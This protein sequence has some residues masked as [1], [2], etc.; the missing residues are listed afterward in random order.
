M[1]DRIPLDHLTSDALDA[2]YE[3]LEA[4][5]QTESERQLAT[6]REALASATTRAARAEVTVARVQAL[7]DRW[8]KAGPPPLGTPI[9]RWWDRRLVE[10]NTALNEEQPGPA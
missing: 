2:L 1:T 10:L 5:E 9:S 6:A 7:A 8:V 3:Q 4:A